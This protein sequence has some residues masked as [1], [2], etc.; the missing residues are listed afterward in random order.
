MATLGFVGDV[1]PGPGPALGF[2]SEVLDGLGGLDLLVANLESPLTERVDPTE[3]KGTHL[4]SNPNAA[5]VLNDLGIDVVS[6]ANNHM[7]DFGEDGFGDTATRLDSLGIR[8][9]GAGFDLGSAR[10]P[11]IIEAAGLAVGLLAYSDRSIETVCATET[12]AGC[13]PLEP[14]LVVEDVQ[15]LVDDV[16][17]VVVLLH[18]GLIGYEL[19]TPQQR[20]IASRVREAGA[21]LVVGSHPHIVQGTESIGSGLIDFSLGDFAFYPASASGRPVNQFRTRQTGAILRV[22]V[23]PGRVESFELVLTRQTGSHIAMETSVGRHRAV[24]AASR[25]LAAT[26]DPYRRRWKRY[27]LVRTAARTIKRL[28]PW[29]WRTI[30]PGTIRGFGV[31]MKE[32]LRRRP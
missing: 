30:R 18:W 26:G 24:A 9:L 23:E 10:R 28:A 2:S 3:I 27:V 13:A 20:G 6:L 7:F 4:R 1:Y 17:V 32:L 8:W 12:S 11:L 25:R 21:T 5:G 16:D 29:R 15:A 31:A 19:P 22:D 14:D